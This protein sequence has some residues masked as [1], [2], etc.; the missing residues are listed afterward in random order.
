MIYVI[1]IIIYRSIRIPSGKTEAVKKLLFAVLMLVSSV[2]FA[3]SLSDSLNSIESEWATIYYGLPKQKQQTAYPVLLDKLQQLAK[4]YPNDAGV[5]YWQALIKAS[6]ADH[7]NPLTALQ[8][9][10]EVRDLL[11]KAIAIN[12]QVMN[13]AAYVV[14]GTLYDKVPSWPIAFGNDNTAKTMLETALKINPNGIANNYFYGKFLL[15]HDDQKAAEHYF[16]LALA[17]PIR[18]EQPYADQQMKLK[19]QHALEKIN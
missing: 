5:I 10:N 17:A 3:D 19:V 9:V 6:S 16:N 1:T 11:T 12:P 2:C 7:Q 14:L 4:T 13:G 8:T 15:S 18:P